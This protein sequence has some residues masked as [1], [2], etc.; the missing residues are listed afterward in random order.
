MI[1]GFCIL[2]DNPRARFWEIKL[3]TPKIT[4]KRRRDLNV[5]FITQ[6]TEVNSVTQLRSYVCAVSHSFK[7]MS[8]AYNCIYVHNFCINN[9]SCHLQS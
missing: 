6:S 7:G 8:C 4:H 2:V 1:R 9:Q 3:Y 5:S